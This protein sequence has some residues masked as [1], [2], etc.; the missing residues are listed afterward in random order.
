MPPDPILFFVIPVPPSLNNRFL[1][2]RRTPFKLNQAVKEY[3]DIVSLLAISHQFTPLTGKL[4]AQVDIFR[5]SDRGD[6]DNYEKA[7]WDSL[8][9]ILY[10]DDKQIKRHVITVHVDRSNPRAEVS[11]CPYHPD[12]FCL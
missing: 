8:Q 10:H 9:G 11:I 12:L 6:A 3:K 7:L 4:F 1:P 5:P 2:N